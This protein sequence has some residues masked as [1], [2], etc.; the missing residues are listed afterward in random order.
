LKTNVLMLV[1][2]S[3]LH[4]A[5]LTKRPSDLTEKMKMAAY[6]QN[7]S[8]SATKKNVHQ[9]PVLTSNAVVADSVNQ[10]PS[11]VLATV[12]KTAVTLVIAVLANVIS[13]LA[14]MLLM[15][16]NA[17][18]PLEIWPE[19]FA[20]KVYS[21]TEKRWLNLPTV[22][23]KSTVVWFHPDTSGRNLVIPANVST[24]SNNASKNHAPRSLAVKVTSL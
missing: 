9:L 12:L 19:L 10:E 7:S 11:K 16:L 8:V 2:R 4:A 23:V 22:H 5:N 24:V 15:F 13:Q 18:C 20:A 3:K 21:A 6:A 17:L 14:H 1:S